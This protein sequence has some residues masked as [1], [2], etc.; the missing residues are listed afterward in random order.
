MSGCGREYLPDMQERLVALADVREYSGGPSGCPGRVGRPSRMSAVVGS[1]SRMTGSDREA[2][3]DV[4]EW[5]VVV[6]SS[7]TTLPNIQEW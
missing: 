4:R 3:P 2:L 6:S 1:L 7:G 5:S